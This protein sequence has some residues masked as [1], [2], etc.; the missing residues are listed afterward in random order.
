M[1][2][3]AEPVRA[4][5]AAR[6]ERTTGVVIRSGEMRVSHGV[7]KGGSTPPPATMF[8][9]KKNKEDM[10]NGIFTGKEAAWA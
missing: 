1:S 9:I 3:A 2:Y 10:K 5:P 7:G 6:P 4:Y 8:N